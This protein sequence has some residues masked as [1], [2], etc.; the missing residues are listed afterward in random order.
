M[1]I[2]PW[3]YLAAGLAALWFLNRKKAPATPEIMIQ[4]QNLYV[5]P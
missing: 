1:T 3:M 5:D 4:E 2:K